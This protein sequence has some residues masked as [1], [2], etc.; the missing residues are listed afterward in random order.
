MDLTLLS[1]ARD[2]LR[3]EMTGRI[4]RNEATLV[5]Q[6]FDGLLGPEGYTRNALLSL[7][8]TTFIDVSS[9][10]WLLVLHKR[11]RK[12]G[13]QLVVHSVCP[14]VMASLEM[15]HFELVL[16]IAEDEAAALELLRSQDS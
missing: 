4:V 13:G 12:A 11:F 7:A 10:S 1:D 3:L 5:L 2:A 15:V 9:L 14:P 8:E 6:S 16:H